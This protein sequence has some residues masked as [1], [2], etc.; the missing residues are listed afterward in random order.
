MA[1][2]KQLSIEVQTICQEVELF[3]IWV[4]YLLQRQLKTHSNVD[5]KRSAAEDKHL[6][7]E[8]KR[9]ERKLLLN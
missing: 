5:R 3:Y 2:W 6:I 8:S 1:E 7:I 4:Q 9:H